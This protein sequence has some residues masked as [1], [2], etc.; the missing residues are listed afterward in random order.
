MKHWFVVTI[1]G[2]ICLYQHPSRLFSLQ[3][4]ITQFQK[5]LTDVRITTIHLFAF[6]KVGSGFISLKKNEDVKYEVTFAPRTKIIFF[7]QSKC[8][9]SKCACDQNAGSWNLK[10]S[11]IKMRAIEM[12]AIKMRA[13]SKCARDRNMRDWNARDRNARSWNGS[14]RALPEAFLGI[15]L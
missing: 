11:G 5:L 15:F 6:V 9:R 13:R 14:R 2:S 7:F 12:R 3:N 4:N 10:C 1:D 8:A